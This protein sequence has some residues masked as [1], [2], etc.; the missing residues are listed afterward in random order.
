VSGIFLILEGF[1]PG[2]FGHRGVVIIDTCN[3]FGSN[4]CMKTITLKNI[5]DTLHRAYRERAQQ[6][7]RSLNREILHTL[8]A[9]L[10]NTI[11]SREAVVT[12]TRKR[13]AR[14]SE[15]RRAAGRKQ[16]TNEAFLESIREGRE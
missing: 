14:Q 7:A 5:P 11:P 2:F 6:H 3:R 9:A 16:L 12:R 15:R 13:V 1:E 10:E 4:F 8:E